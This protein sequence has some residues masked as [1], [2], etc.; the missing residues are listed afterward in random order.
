MIHPE[1][2]STRVGLLQVR[3]VLYCRSLG[4]VK[5]TNFRCCNPS[6]PSGDIEP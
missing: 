6:S 2:M 1:V 4:V 5:K 3:V